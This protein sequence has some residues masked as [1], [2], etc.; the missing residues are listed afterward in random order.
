M[1]EKKK[2]KQ[3]ESLAFWSAIFYFRKDSS[4]VFS[5]IEKVEVKLETFPKIAIVGK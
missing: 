4:S 3:S 1:K 5:K 2:T